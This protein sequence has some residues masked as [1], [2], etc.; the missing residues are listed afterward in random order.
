MGLLKKKKKK[1]GAAARYASGG[2]GGSEI[3]SQRPQAV[4]KLPPCVELLGVATVCRRCFL[5]GYL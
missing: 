2:G 3:S 5:I 4:D 1:K